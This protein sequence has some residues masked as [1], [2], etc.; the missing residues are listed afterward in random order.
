M[1]AALPFVW[2]RLS[3]IFDFLEWDAACGSALTAFAVRTFAGRE[4]KIARYTPW[5]FSE[6]Q[7]VPATA[8]AGILR[9]HSVHES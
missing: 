7:F 2:L 5:R 8:V 6:S 1:R 9:S 3:K 4:E